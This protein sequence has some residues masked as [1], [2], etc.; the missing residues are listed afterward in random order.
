MEAVKEG[1]N[2]WTLQPRNP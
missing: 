2:K 1:Y